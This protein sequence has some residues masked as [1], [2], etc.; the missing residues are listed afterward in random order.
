MELMS[1]GLGEGRQPE[2]ARIRTQ[3]DSHGNL[4]KIP[5]KSPLGLEPFPEFRAAEILD[6]VRDDAAADEDAAAR[7]EK[8]CQV[9]GERAKQ[10]AERVERLSA[11]GAAA[12]KRCLGNLR[13]GPR[14]DVGAVDRRSRAIKI[15]QPIA[16]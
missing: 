5:S 3:D 13:S 1:I 14:D 8:Q 4:R 11:C 10:C 7:T 9:A 16:G 15:D 12:I 2:E 6:D